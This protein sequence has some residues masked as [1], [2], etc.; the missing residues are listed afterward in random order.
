MVQWCCQGFPNAGRR[1]LGNGPS[2]GSLFSQGIPGR[3]STPWEKDDG[4]L[5]GRL[6]EPCD[7]WMMEVRSCRGLPVLFS[8]LAAVDPHGSR[9]TSHL[10][11]VY[12]A[13]SPLRW[14]GTWRKAYR[15]SS[16]DGYD[17]T[18]S[19]IDIRSER[20]NHVRAKEKRSGKVLQDTMK[21]VVGCFKRTVNP[22]ESNGANLFKDSQVFWDSADEDRCCVF[23]WRINSLNVRR[24]AIA[25]NPPTETCLFCRARSHGAWKDGT[26]C[27]LAAVV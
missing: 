19:P 21:V 7:Y 14:G 9:C 3:V 23:R 25:S 8:P 18:E 1:W 5:W 13:I 27:V 4:Y 2:D 10:T 12:E 16:F 6:L 24:V 20:A 11:Q 15:L 22:I 26:Y 17:S